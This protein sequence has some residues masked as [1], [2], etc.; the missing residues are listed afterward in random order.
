MSIEQLISDYGYYAVAFFA[1][2]EGEVAMITAGIL[3]CQKI[4]YL[5]YV[6]AFAFLGT[7]ITEQVLFFLGRFYG[8]KI[9]NKYSY[10]QE[11][12]IKV[13]EL[14][15]KYDSIYIFC[16]RFIYGIRNV[17]PIIIGSAM[18]DPKKY[19]I[20]NF[21]AALIWSILIPSVGFYF[22]SFVKNNVTDIKTYV[23]IMCLFV[24][25]LSVIPYVIYK[26]IQK[27]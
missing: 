14:I 25:A 18:I 27:K 9:I 26:F 3:A 10:I 13:F 6:M 23:A 19:F 15:R 7:F 24:V 5:P 21:L 2:I 16:F 17:S 4:L 1:C 12:S 20:I 22:S 11:K 8:N